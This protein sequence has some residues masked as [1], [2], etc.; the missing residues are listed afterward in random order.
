MLRISPHLVLT[1][2]ELCSANRLRPHAAK[3]SDPFPQ[4]HAWKGKDFFN[5]Q[6]A[7]SIASNLG[8]GGRTA[9]EF[10]S[11]SAGSPSESLCLWMSAFSV[12]DRREHTAPP[13]T[14]R[15]LISPSPTEE[16]P[17]FSRLFV[18]RA[19]LCPP[20]TSAKARMSVHAYA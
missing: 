13:V 8:G 11:S 4:K 14:S 1:E 10:F 5:V 15:R 16:A 12:Q 19:D 3:S 20:V 7:S 6:A 17:H 9:R 2:R 18:P